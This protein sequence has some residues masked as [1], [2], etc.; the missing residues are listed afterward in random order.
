MEQGFLNF[1]QKKTTNL[2]IALKKLS[3]GKLGTTVISF[4]Y[5]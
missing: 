1:S 5:P 2:L 4:F 3:L